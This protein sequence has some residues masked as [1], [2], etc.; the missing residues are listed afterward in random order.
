[1][2]QP[3]ADVTNRTYGAKGDGI[4]DDAPAARA[5]LAAVM[6]VG[7]GTVYFPK[8][9]YRFASNSPQSSSTPF[10]AQGSHIR[11]KCAPEAVIDAGGVPTTYSLFMFVYPTS[12]QGGMQGVT[13]YQA[14]VMALA[15]S[16]SIT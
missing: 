8:G 6:A 14:N 10:F 15:G 11:V 12:A 4:T 2:L 13:G 3:V 7:G 1:A 16:S 5:A 9:T